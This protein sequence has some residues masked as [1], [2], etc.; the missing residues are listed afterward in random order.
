MK[1]LQE[2][3]LGIHLHLEMQ[4]ISSHDW[5]FG[6]DLSEYNNPADYMGIP[7]M[8]GISVIYNGTPKPPTPEVK[9]NSNKWYKYM[10]KKLIIRL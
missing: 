9:G 10:S 4:D 1:E 8:E 7:N 5:I 6:A 3:A 2:Q